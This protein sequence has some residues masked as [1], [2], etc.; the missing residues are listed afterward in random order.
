MRTVGLCVG[1]LLIAGITV[2]LVSY[3]TSQFPVAHKRVVVVLQAKTT[4]HPATTIQEPETLF[5]VVEIEERNM[6][7][8]AITAD[9]MDSLKQR[10]LKITCDKDMILTEDMFVFPP[11]KQAVAV[12]VWLDAKR[13]RYFPAGPRAFHVPAS[14]SVEAAL[15]HFPLPGTE[16]DLIYT[17]DGKTTVLAEKVLVLV[18][19]VPSRCVEEL[20]IAGVTV[21]LQVDVEQFQKIVEARASDEITLMLRASGKADRPARQAD[22]LPPDDDAKPK[23]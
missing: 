11:G 18:I 20:G 17:K 7:P 22:L 21:T 10:M 3:F 16:V 13:E 2:L 23:K 15:A 14:R 19:D 5:E 4:I 6:P 1:F 9:R 12:P 8:N